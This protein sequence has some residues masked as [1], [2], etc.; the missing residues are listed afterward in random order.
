MDLGW[1]RG[2]MVLFMRV[3]L[4]M[5]K[6]MGKEFING[7]KVA[8]I[9]VNGN[10]IKF[11]DT[12]NMNGLMEGYLVQLSSHTLVLGSTI[13]CMAEGSIFGKMENATMANINSI[14]S[15]GLVSFTGLTENNTK[16]IG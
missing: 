7:I 4:K 12:E 11:M 6:K 5:G 14:K 1:K 13:K 10:T 2:Q 9:M 3:P 8:N 16:A 15:K